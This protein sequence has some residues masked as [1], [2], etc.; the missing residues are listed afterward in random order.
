M[1]RLS[2]DYYE[3]RPVYIE[4]SIIGNVMWFSVQ[5][6][7]RRHQTLLTEGLVSKV[8]LSWFQLGFLSKWNAGFGNEL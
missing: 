4:V 8:P 1:F 7:Y 6:I 5:D 2:C 3:W